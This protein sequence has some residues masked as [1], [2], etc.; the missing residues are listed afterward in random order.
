VGTSIRCVETSPGDRKVVVRNSEENLAAIREILQ[1]VWPDAWTREKL[2]DTML[3]EVDFRDVPLP[4]AL[5]TL[6]EMSRTHDPW[7]GEHGKG[8]N[9]LFA[10]TDAVVAKRITFQARE[11][12]LES[13]LGAI[14]DLVG[15]IYE[16]KGD[17][18]M[19]R[20]GA[21]E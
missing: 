7:Q 13:A 8:M 17:V 20:I 9:I 11:I 21:V 6:S 5:L 10:V 3:P 15:G 2:C 1:S 16:I 4:A 12:T 19:V 14:C 18:V